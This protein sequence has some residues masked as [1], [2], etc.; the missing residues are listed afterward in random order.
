M[1]ETQDPQTTPESNPSATPSSNQNLI[2][3]IVMGAVVLLLLLVINQQFNKDDTHNDDQ[4][5]LALKKQLDDQKVTNNSMRFATGTNNAQS[6]TALADAIKRDTQTLAELVNASV[7]NSAELGTA[8]QALLDSQAANRNLQAQLSQYQNTASRVPTLEAQIAD[9]QKSL[10]GAVDKLT[11]DSIRDELSR[12]KIERD[13]LL[14]EIA[15][16]K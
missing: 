13:K 9:L 15:Q 3:G 2:L 10:A 5:L 11:A 8:N 6:A 1:A 4:K 14:A 7:T 12:V 16:L